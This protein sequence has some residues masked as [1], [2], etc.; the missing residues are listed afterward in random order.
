MCIYFHR[1]ERQ[2]NRKRE[3][4]RHPLVHSPNV[5][6]SPDWARPKSGL[7]VP[8]GTPTGWWGPEHWSRHPLPRRTREQETGSEAGQAGLNA[9]IQPGVRPH[10]PHDPLPHLHFI[11]KAER[12]AEIFHVPVHSPNARNGWGWTSLSQEP[13][14]QSCLPCGWQGPGPSC[15]LPRVH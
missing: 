12:Q 1:L 8:S 13:G 2:R 5:R 9:A 6:N 14:T 3:T 10:L 11:S 7:G 4:D 15:C